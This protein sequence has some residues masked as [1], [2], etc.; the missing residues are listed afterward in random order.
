MLPRLKN[1]FLSSLK[2]II[3][4]FARFNG[5]ELLTKEQT[6]LFLKNAKI[7][8]HDE[9]FIELLPVDTYG[10]TIEDFEKKVIVKCGSSAVY[11]LSGE[12]MKILPYGGIQIG[13][14]VLD[15]DFGSSG[16]LRSCFRT[17]KRKKIFSKNCIVLWSHKWG[18]GYYDYLFF[19]YAKLL[20]IKE[21]IGEE[22]FKQSVVLYPVFGKSFEKELW[23]LAGL[24][25]NQ[26]F[27]VNIYKVEAKNFYLANN[28]SWF[29]PN[30]RCIE[31]LRSLSISHS[32]NESPELRRIY[33]SRK[34]RRILIN[35]DQIYEVL[36]EFGFEIIEDKPRT[37][38][39]QMHL[40]RNAAIII[41]PHGASFSNILWC[42]PQTTLIELFS[43]K[44]YP[45]YFKYLA[46]VLGLKYHAII[47]DN[48]HVSD[49][50]YS[51]K[52]IMISPEVIRSAL[53]R[54]LPN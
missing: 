9:N 16:Y 48:V 23:T 27:D 13:S 47:E 18:G 54:I 22:E 8:I 25:E 21:V 32:I 26:V 7:N 29:Y 14:K 31:N 37:I 5:I 34:H 53:H 33:I 51:S 30:M 2:K 50:S 4:L 17:V 3:P 49:Y 36:K 43:N 12:D 1:R 20:R 44:Y 39:E 10:G 6:L 19:I 52:N 45:P 15:M 42:R 46:F 11:R 38:K 24:E 40:Y 41:G 28:G 35:E